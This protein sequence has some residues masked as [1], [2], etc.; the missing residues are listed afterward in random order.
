[1]VLPNSRLRKVCWESRMEEINT[2]SIM[3]FTRGCKD[4][5]EKEGHLKLHSHTWTSTH[6][7]AHPGWSLWL[8]FL[9]SR[10]TSQV[11][12]RSQGKSS[13]TTSTVSPLSGSLVKERFHD[14][15][16]SKCQ[17]RYASIG[18]N[19]HCGGDTVGSQ[20]TKGRTLLRATS[21]NLLKT[22][23]CVLAVLF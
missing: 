8:V 7:C 3:Q 11:W 1:M 23:S 13:L 21:P 16:V 9:F 10:Y 20:S 4:Q 17:V 5:S 15:H 2:Q 19:T 18:W 14:F 22:I 12:I 6:T